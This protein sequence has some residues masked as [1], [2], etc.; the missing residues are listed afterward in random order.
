MTFSIS[1]LTISF[2][3]SRTKLLI[4]LLPVLVMFVISVELL[5]YMCLGQDDSLD[6]LKCSSQKVLPS[7]F[8][9]FQFFNITCNLK[10]MTSCMKSGE[11][12]HFTACCLILHQVVYLPVTSN[13]ESWSN[14]GVVFGT[15]ACVKLRLILSQFHTR[16][17][18]HL[19]WATLL[20]HHTW[21]R[22]NP[23]DPRAT[24]FFS[25]N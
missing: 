14:C 12:K 1:L 7:V 22:R 13:F 6:S 4:M 18:Q 10:H 23:V 9:F 17:N 11:F 5:L 20:C 16:Q 15:F 8:T 25:K 24:V 19:P 2:L 3:L 21:A